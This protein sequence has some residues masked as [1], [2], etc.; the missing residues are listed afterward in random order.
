MLFDIISIVPQPPE[1]RSDQA[2]LRGGVFC[3][4]FFAEE[5]K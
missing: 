1:G 5:E 2:P 4:L 3:L